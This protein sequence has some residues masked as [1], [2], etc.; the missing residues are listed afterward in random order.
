[1]VEDGDGNVIVV[2][3]FYLF[4][5]SLL[6]CGPI[7][8]IMMSPPETREDSRVAKLIWPAHAVNIKTPHE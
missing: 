8:K 3:V 1:M 4:K 2:L 6:I 5:Y 7:R